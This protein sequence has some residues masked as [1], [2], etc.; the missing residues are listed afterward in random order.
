MQEIAPSHSKMGN[1]VAW[2]GKDWNNEMARPESWSKPTTYLRTILF[3]N[4][5]QVHLNKLEYFI[6]PIKKNIVSELL[7]FWKVCSFTVYVL[8]T[9]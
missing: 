5:I 2:C 8:N 6:R 9:W 4:Y 7:A 3:T 1:H